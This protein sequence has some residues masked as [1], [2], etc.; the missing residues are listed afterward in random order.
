MEINRYI[1]HTILKAT[2]T[3]AEITQL[4]DEAKEH[5]FFSVCVN[6]CYV[7]LA[8]KLLAGTEVDVCT[9]VG[10]PLGQMDKDSKVF[11]AAQAIRNGATEVDMV[12]NVG[13]LKSG[14]TD[15]VREEIRAIKEAIGD[16]VLKVIIETCYLTKEEIKLASELTVEAGADFIKT[17]T[18]FG[19][20]GALVE[21]V[22]IMLEVA[23]DKA[24]V[25]ASGGVR[26]FATAKQYIDMGVMRLG[27]SS[28][29]KLM[30][31]EE[32]GE[33]DY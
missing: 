6:T 15:E 21:D 4:C 2:A 18:G 17:S 7:P 33:N 10:F 19:T 9:V 3:D 8:A 26:D 16:H 14:K 27:T 28:G 11:E 20:G 29:I 30:K 24:K 1:D 25:K 31:G 13:F 23:G 5:N 22:K 32:L 12:I